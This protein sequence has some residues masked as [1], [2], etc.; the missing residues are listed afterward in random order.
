MNAMCACSTHCP[1]SSYHEPR[2]CDE[3][4][5]D[6]WC[7]TVKWDFCI[8][9]RAKQTTDKRCSQFCNFVPTPFNRGLSGTSCSNESS[10]T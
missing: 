7:H 5:C 3:R 6:C 4:G 8:C 10:D 9:G 2:C 1:L